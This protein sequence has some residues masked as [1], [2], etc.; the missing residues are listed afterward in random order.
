VRG[1]R[2]LGVALLMTAVAAAHRGD[3]VKITEFTI[4]TA[5]AEPLRIVTGP[6]GR[7]WFTEFGANKIGAMTPSGAF[8]EYVVPTANSG[9]SGIAGP[10]GVQLLFTE[11]TAGKLGSVAVDGTIADGPGTLGQPTDV[12]YA[13]PN[14]FVTEF[15]TSK[16]LVVGTFSTEFTTPGAGP[17]SIVIGGDGYVWFTEYDANRIARCPLPSGACQDF[18]IPTPAS[19]PTGIALAA[20]KTIWFVEADGNKVGKV[21][22]QG[23]DTQITEYP[24]PTASSSPFGITAGPDG[25]MWFTEGAASA[26]KIGR[27]T[28]AGVISE[29]PVPTASSRPAGITLGPGNALFFTE[30]AGN[31]IGKIH[32]VVPGDVDGDGDVNVADVFYL[33]NYLFAGGP[34][35]HAPWAFSGEELQTGTR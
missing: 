29:F 7:L 31:K 14:P 2:F 17:H 12:A 21:F 20:D 34:P 1:S 30:Y 8:T 19:H 25:N 26:S 15:S 4:P 18:P 23:A 35:P 32:V 11:S 16:I 10:P 9:P 24:I 33:I 13:Y 5:S 6:D 3:A 22:R 28:P 27:I